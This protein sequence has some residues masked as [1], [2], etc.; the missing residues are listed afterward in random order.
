MWRLSLKS[1]IV[2]FSKGKDKIA[3]GEIRN[4]NLR[5]SSDL[6]TIYL[7][8]FYPQIYKKKTKDSYEIANSTVLAMT[9]LN[10]TVVW[11]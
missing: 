1:P 2:W 9:F 3:V 6:W 10:S 7:F 11:I 8:P 4:N 5:F